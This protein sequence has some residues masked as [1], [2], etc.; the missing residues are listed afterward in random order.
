MKGQRGT[1]TP[2]QGQGCYNDPNSYTK[3]IV[4]HLFILV[5]YDDELICST[6]D[7]KPPNYG[8]S[9]LKKKFCMIGLGKLQYL[10]GIQ[11]L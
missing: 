1:D 8:K 7:T 9:I 5:L 6:S 3:Q 2:Q 11:V 10:L 4:D